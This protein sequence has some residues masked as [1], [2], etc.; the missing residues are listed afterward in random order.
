MPSLSNC[1]Q[2]GLFFFGGGG[3]D[4]LVLKRVEGWSVI[5]DRHLMVYQEKRINFD[6]K[7][8]CSYIK[9]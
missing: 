4:Y 2:I 6:N 5:I 3:G 9:K 8:L 1:A 7:R